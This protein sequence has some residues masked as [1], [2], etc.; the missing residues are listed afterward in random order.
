MGEDVFWNVDLEEA[1]QFLK[2]M[3]RVDG[4]YV[5]DIY[6]I[7]QGEERCIS[8]SR[9]TNRLMLNVLD[10]EIEG[11]PGESLE[12]VVSREGVG[13]IGVMMQRS[14]GIHTIVYK[15]HAAELFDT[16]Y[17]MHIPF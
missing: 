2:E 13:E 10:L 4:K 6:G 5:V 17:K 7:Y 16:L 15:D 12:I 1:I 8:S 9:A 11:I 3:M 14:D